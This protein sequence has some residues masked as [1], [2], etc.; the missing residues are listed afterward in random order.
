[1]KVGRPHQH[2]HKA[3]GISR[4]SAGSNTTLDRRGQ[5]ALTR[6]FIALRPARTLSDFVW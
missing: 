1:M 3:Y 6:T 5:P 4:T 2:N